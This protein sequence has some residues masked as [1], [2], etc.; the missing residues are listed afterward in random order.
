MYATKSDIYYFPLCPVCHK[1]CLVKIEDYS[2]SV[3]YECFNG[4]SGKKFVSKIKYKTIKLN[5]NN[6]SKSTINKCPLHANK[7]KQNPINSKKCIFCIRKEKDGNEID[8]LTYEIEVLNEAFDKLFK[9]F[10]SNKKNIINFNFKKNEIYKIN[11]LKYSNYYNDEKKNLIIEYLK[12][13]YALHFLYNNSIV[14]NNNELGVDIR[15]N[16]Y[17]KYYNLECPLLMQNDE[18]SDN[19]DHLLNAKKMFNSFKKYKISKT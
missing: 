19:I 18:I 1:L 15:I 14:R 11:W 4:H 3:H 5:N 7:N 10:F 16:N 8:P 13:I 17:E 2:F 12:K 9:K 6:N